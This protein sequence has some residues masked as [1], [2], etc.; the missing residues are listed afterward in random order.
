MSG[1]VPFRRRRS[2]LDRRFDEFFNEFY[3]M[4]DDFFNTPW[5]SNMVQNIGGFRVSIQEKDD[6]YIVEAELPGVRKDEIDIDLDEGRLNIF[7]ERD[8]N[9]GKDDKNYVY[10]ESRQYSMGRSLYLRDAKADGA[11]ARLENG[12]LYINIPK[13]KNISRSK[14]I[15]IE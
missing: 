11:S 14:R 8:E 10:R 3:T 13:E 9:I 12:I 5:P 2:S 4:M 6:E 7:V 15:E 1:L